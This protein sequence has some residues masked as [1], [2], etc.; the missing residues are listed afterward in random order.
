M[1]KSKFEQL[2]DAIEKLIEL[3]IKDMKSRDDDSGCYYYLSIQ[4]AKGDIGLALQN[5][6]KEK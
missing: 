1:H 5:L 4:D 6:L 3:K 2:T